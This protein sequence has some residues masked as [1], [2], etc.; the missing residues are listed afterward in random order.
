MLPSASCLP[1]KRAPQPSLAT[2]RRSC[3][4]TRSDAPNEIAKGLPSNGWIPS[5]TPLGRSVER[6]P[7]VTAAPRLQSS[8]P[9][10][11]YVVT[12]IAVKSDSHAAE[13]VAIRTMVVG[14]WFL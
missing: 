10:R 9:R 4:M 13:R 14:R 8:P 1:S 3:S 2:L 11:R 7:Q 6:S 12:M 5:K